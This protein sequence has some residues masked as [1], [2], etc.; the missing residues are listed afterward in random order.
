MYI[1]RTINREIESSELTSNES[2]CHPSNCQ[3]FYVDSL[4]ELDRIRSRGFQVDVVKQNQIFTVPHRPD[5]S[6]ASFTE[7]E[8]NW[9][10]ENL[11]VQK[12]WELNAR[13]QS[14]KVGIADT[15]I[16]RDH[17]CFASLNLKE[18]VDINIETGEISQPSPYDGAWHGT[19]CAGILCGV[20]SDGMSR[21]VSPDI[22]L[23]VAKAFDGWSGSIIS[24]NKA[25]EW[26]HEKQC[27]IVSLSLGLPG[28]HDDWADA[29]FQLVQGGAIVFAASGNEYESQSQPHTRSP[30]NY[31]LEGLISV[32]AY[33]NQQNI[34]SSSG[35]GIIDWSDDSYFS[36]QRNI[37]VPY[38]TSPGVGIISC[39]PEQG[40]Y[41]NETG[42]SMATPHV[43]G[44]AANILS[45]IRTKGLANEKKLTKQIIGNAIVDF[46]QSGSD[47]RYGKGLLSADKVLEQ[48]QSLAV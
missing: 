23:Y 46:G 18:F 19:H 37:I 14:V 11:R 24:Q 13:G 9:G 3:T 31:P 40:K 7:R 20:E 39:V 47:E 17:N 22:E 12:F 44:I 42:T 10:S 26:F 15:G 33:D 38:L 2:S 6:P 16:F 27:D 5:I 43:A 48:L 30:G 1:V 32:G 29:M 45:Y 8:A 36:G 41:R 35:G 34:W 21:G 28:L 25:L 4:Q